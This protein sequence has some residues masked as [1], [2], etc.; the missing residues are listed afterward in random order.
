MKHPLRVLYHMVKADF[1]ERVRRYSFLLILAGALWLAYGVIAEKVTIVVGDGYRGVY[2]SAWIG[3]LMAICCS[4]FLSLCAFYVV[5]NSVERDSKTRVGRILAATP[6]R[7]EF[8]TVAKTVSNFAVLAS[9]VLV[10]MVA[11]LAMQWLR[12]EARPIS[13]WQ[14][15]SPFLLIA[16]PAMFLTAS[17]AL[18]FETLPVLRSGVGNVIYF[19][20]WNFVLALGVTTRIDDPP[21]I[22]VLQ[23]ST[24]QALQSM[25]LAEKSSRFSLTIGPNH[26]ARTFQWNGVDWT[27]HVVAWRLAWVAV[28]LGIALLASL[29]FHRF[30][31]AR[32]RVREKKAKKAVGDEPIAAVEQR[33][34][35]DG[36]T[37]L[38]PVGS[39]GH[40]R[41]ARLVISELSLM[42]KGLRWWWYAMAAGLVIAE[43][44]SP[45]TAAREGVLLAAWLWPVLVWS[46]MGCRESRHSTESLIFSAEHVVYRQ[47]A[48]LWTA[49]VV[50]AIAT[51]AG[52]GV[53]LLIGG[54]WQMLA[55]WGAGALFI[56]SMALAFGV[57]SGSSK[58]FEAL[59]TVWWYVGPL[60]Q[61]PSLDFVGGSQ[62]SSTPVLYL[63]LAA[64]LVLAASLGRRRQ[65]AYA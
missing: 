4:T 46:Q 63:T 36:H 54:N 23:N 53:R 37:T 21:G 56:P 57:W 30:D 50:V 41:F 35:V 33:Q 6:M 58:F 47:L 19:F 22:H 52:A 20:V 59:Y 48:A 62:A 16:L 43:F 32:E 44:A 26:P 2:N 14:L 49:G 8:Y 27:L 15:W 5:K 61:L 9:M 7:K 12:P 28:G 3:M 31:P 24:Q 10:L 1:L 25:N 60:H 64:G 45:T 40:S 29:F 13:L 51:G 11:A 17:A 38:S 42:V 39:L 34:T 18:L 55:A 65:V